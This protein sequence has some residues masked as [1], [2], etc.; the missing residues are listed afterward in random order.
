MVGQDW[1]DVEGETR[2]IY[3]LIGADLTDPVHVVSVGESLFGYK[4]VIYQGR[5]R[6]VGR[7]ALVLRTKPQLQLFCV[8]PRWQIILTRCQ[9]WRDEPLLIGH[10]IFEWRVKRL[11]LI[12]PWA[13]RWCWAGARSLVMPGPSLNKVVTRAIF[14][15][16][17]ADERGIRGPHRFK[18]IADF[19]DV[20]Q[21]Q[22]AIRF[23]EYLGLPM[24]LV[25]RRG[26]P[27]AV[28]EPWNWGSPAFMQTLACAGWT[29][30]EIRRVWLSCGT[31]AMW[32]CGEFGP[33]FDID[34]THTMQK[35]LAASK[36]RPSKP[37]L[38]RNPGLRCLGTSP[39]SSATV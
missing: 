1:P 12:S 36:K 19:F 26:P 2:L 38:P 5:M 35:V 24:A 27:V 30:R 11:N 20:T 16:T 23:A 28:G 32:P 10:E 3:D 33:P 21:V 29:P 25:P 31:V 15:E 37:R 17:R 18:I 14:E 9:N 13:E 22:A 34:L 8:D 4:G 39:S 6:V 7:A